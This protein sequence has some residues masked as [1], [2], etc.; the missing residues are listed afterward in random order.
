MNFLANPML[1]KNSADHSTDKKA[2]EDIEKG[3]NRRKKEARMRD[4][5][6]LFNKLFISPIRKE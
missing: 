5:L 4:R 6:R 1:L 3:Q 2:E